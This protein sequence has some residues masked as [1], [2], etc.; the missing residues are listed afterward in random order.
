MIA[1]RAANLR[2][3][4][5]QAVSRLMSVNVDGDSARLT[6]PVTYPSGSTCTVE[7]I[8]NGDKCFVSDL[9]LGHMEAELH[10][11]D[12]F[13]GPAAKKAA[14]NYGVSYDGMSVFAIWGSIDRVES[15]VTAVANASASA[16]AA[17]I[18]RAAEERHK[19]C[20]FEVY[21]RI[22]AIFPPAS[23]TK[24]MV[25]YGNEADWE[26]H[27]VVTL[28]DRR[29]VFEFVSESQ[30][31]IASKFMMF[32]DLSR[33]SQS[34]SLNSVVKNVERIGKKGAML[35]DVSNVIPLDASRDEYVRF[36]RAA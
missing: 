10:G 21:E 19:Q 13:Y 23:V 31:S 20:N 34:I 1:V 5:S 6:V 32:S 9:A 4:L 26:A 3:R 2:D 27:N 16:A 12:E 11:A 24:T 22:L 30:I 25:L 17:A 18:L 35:A 14:G 29:A 8:L 28:P 7:I 36:A 33:A 15:A